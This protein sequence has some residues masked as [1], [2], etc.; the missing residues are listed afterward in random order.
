MCRINAIN[1]AAALAPEDMFVTDPHGNHVPNPQFH[2]S[3]PE[4][5]SSYAGPDG[6]LGARRRVSGV[7]AATRSKG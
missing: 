6:N 1:A 3:H 5:L 2:V 7:S 4:Q